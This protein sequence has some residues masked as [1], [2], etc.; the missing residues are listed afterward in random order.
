[1]KD[2][3]QATQTRREAR[4]LVGRFR[5]GVLAPV[6]IVPVKGREGGL[7]SHSITGEL[8]AIIG[9]V[10][11]PVTAELISVFVPVQAM[12]ML[13]NPATAYAGVTEVVRDKLLSG[14]PL[15][16]L[17][18]E[19]VLS[20]RMG[21][22][23]RMTA[24]VR[25][26]SE[27]CRLGHNAA[28]NHLR[29]RRYHKAAQLLAASTAL[30]PALI[31]QTVLDRFNAV[32]D[33]DDRINGA[34]QLDLPTLQLPVSGLTLANTGGG[35][36][37]AAN[38]T[39]SASTAQINNATG[40]SLTVQSNIFATLNGQTA[41]NVSLSD[42]YIAERADRMVRD[43]DRIIRD[44]PQF[45][46]EMVLRWAHALEVDA[47]K[48]PWVIAERTTILNRDI[49]GAM[50]TAGV[51]AETLRSDLTFQ[52][53]FTVPVPRTELGGVVVT[54]ATIKPDEVLA[55]QPHPIL[56]APWVVDNY[57][58]QSLDID[59]KPVRVRDLNA[60]GPQAS[61]TNIVFYTGLNELQRNYVHY[62]LN[63]AV[64]AATLT[65]KTVLWQY[66]IPLSVTP[67]S[68]LYPASLPHTPFVDTTA[69]VCTYSASW[70]Y[71][72]RTPTIFGP[73]PIETYAVIDQ[74]T[75]L[76]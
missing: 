33:P 39:V 14:N 8:D 27:V 3:A 24:G 64:S 26:V 74:Q 11:T 68:I 43:M 66:A 32:L 13:K 18:A 42:F 31:S 34:V 29:Q 71:A 6:S 58:A 49:V 30:T 21:V 52:L 45:G 69:E 12:D 61:E 20:Q 5:G 75:L 48:E 70:S 40:G 76:T 65:E 56:S 7:L 19:N 44:N 73:T 17:E 55:D 53:G 63:R 72:F 50:D 41:G 28:V 25:Q 16:V 22:I 37:S 1:M 46:E 54:F 67:D 51:R 2:F 59:P 62:G 35:A 36:T 57:V 4:T 47:G 9:R 10:L 23:P 60:N 15:F 38:M